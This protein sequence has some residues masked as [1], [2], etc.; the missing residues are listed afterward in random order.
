MA[1]PIK[2]RKVQFLPETTCFVPLDRKGE[3][4]ENII[5]RVEELE[6]MRLKDIKGLTQQQ[7]ADKMNISRQTFQNIIDSGRKKVVLALTKGK[8][9]NIKGGN[10]ALSSCKLKCKSC[11][12]TYDMNYIKDKNICPFCNSNKVICKGKNKDCKGICSK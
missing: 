8:A 11:N 2:C 9:I 7:C 1:R 4:G 5:L 10:Y 3:E 6:A 12:N